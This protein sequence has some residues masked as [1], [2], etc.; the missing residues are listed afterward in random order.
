[1]K[2]ENQMV[3]SRVLKF[4]AWDTNEKMMYKNWTDIQVFRDSD[5]LIPM[6]FT[7]I[8]DKNGKK[9]YEG[10][11][12]KVD[13][14]IVEVKAPELFECDAFVVYGYN[15]CSGFFIDNYDKI[16]LDRFYGYEPEIIGNIYENPKLLTNPTL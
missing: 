6:Q 9:I 16:G 12:I 4:R 13:D 7:G 10:D 2:K 11:I 3:N 15:F 8:K 5:V 1:M 14:E